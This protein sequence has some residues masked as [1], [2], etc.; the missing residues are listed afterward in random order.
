[1]AACAAPAPESAT[2]VAA[3]SDGTVP[4]EPATAPPPAATPDEAQAGGP[5]RTRPKPPPLRTGGPLPPERVG[6][7]KPD[8]NT[9]PVQINDRCRTD[10]DCT[11][12][13]VGNCCGY[14]P[15][16]V[17]V[18]SPTDPEGVQR[19]CAK[20]GMASVCGWEEISSCSCVQG[21]CQGN[22]SGAA[23]Q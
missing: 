1:M 16:C 18:D 5:A 23:V 14:Y 19:Q 4:A 21:H 6:D 10:A 20:S 12:K 9:T 13:N 3:R 8:P 2:A 7:R 17:N 22:S 15:A 11:V